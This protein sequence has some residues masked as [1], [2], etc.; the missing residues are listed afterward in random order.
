MLSQNDTIKDRL[1][2]PQSSCYLVILE[3]IPIIF[4]LAEY[5]KSL[6]CKYPEI[7]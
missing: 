6:K 3:G 7:N 2:L 1:F 5:G 4:S